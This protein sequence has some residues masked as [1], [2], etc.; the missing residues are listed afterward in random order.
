VA[1]ARP[2]RGWRPGRSSCCASAMPDV[3]PGSSFQRGSMDYLA[4]IDGAFSA[5]CNTLEEGIWVRFLRSLER[6]R[7]ARVEL[8]ADVESASKLVAKMDVS[9]AATPT[10][11][12]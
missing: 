8:T 3:T 1:A 12:G 4:P 7:P 11:G 10:R 2:W 6:G 9:Y 5:T